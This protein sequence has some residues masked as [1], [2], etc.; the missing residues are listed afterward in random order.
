MF[1]ESPQG[2]VIPT[3]NL[4]CRYGM[5][6]PSLV[7]QGPAMASLG[8]VRW[9]VMPVF[10]VAALAAIVGIRMAMWPCGGLDHD[11]GCKSRVALDLAAVELDPA[12]TE[13]NYQ[14]FDL[15][16]RAEV[17][18]V[19]LA[20]PHDDGWRGVLALFD[21]RTGAL[22]RVLHSSDHPSEDHDEQATF[23][24][25]LSPDGSQVAAVV[26][27]WNEDERLISLLVYD[28]RDGRVLHR[29][30][31][32]LPDFDCIS[33]LDFSPDG[34]QLQCGYTVHDLVTGQQSSLVIGNDV[35]RPMIADFEPGGTAP[36]GTDVKVHD[37]PTRA[38]IFDSDAS[39]IFAPDSIGLLEVWRAYRENR[40]Q[41]WWT[42]APFR[43]LS[44]VGVWNGQT[45]TLIRRFEANERYRATA[46]A[47]DG[48]HFGF[49]SD[50]FYL[51]VFVR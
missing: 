43:E 5:M 30:A 21:T 12:K 50:S 31:S 40:G 6:G 22:M 37:L 42:P 7:D 46:W 26:I 36:D 10:V 51:S 14:G 45:R 20:G 48:S 28:T 18:L 15:G 23:E 34:R 38:E 24:V 8:A 2:P 44:A 41:R 4:T 35:L 11:S 13:V 47:R 27:D 39:M 19:G 32:D 33:M 1:G 9:W 16:P 49:V 25:A 29:L 17:A 3:L